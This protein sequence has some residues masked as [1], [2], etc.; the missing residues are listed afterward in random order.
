M[1][2]PKLKL[3]PILNQTYVHILA[4]PLDF[5]LRTLRGFLANQGLLLAGAIAYY[6]LLSLLPMLILVVIA[7]SHWVPQ[8]EL[9]AALGRYLEW[10]VPSQSRSLLSDVAGFLDNRA[11]IG[12][13]LVVTMLFFSSLAFSI[14]EKSMGLIFPHR[15]MVAKRHWGVSM[16]L[17][18]AFVLALSCALLAMTILSTGL[19]TMGEHSVHLLGVEWS[20]QGLSG[21][22]LYLLGLA[23][24]ALLLATLYLV[25]PVGRMPLRHALVGGVAATL[26][27]ELLRHLLVLYFTKLS[28]ASVVY[29]S[30]TTAV[31]ALLCMEILAALLLLGAQVISEY[32][33]LENELAAAEAAKPASP[34]PGGG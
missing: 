4:H 12:A 33:R 18:Y 30:L 20:L 24:E 21:L 15:G 9:L 2:L 34:A 16:L 3:P 22:M 28:K 10:L 25:L 11:Y 17:P 8:Q 23:V 6:A 32:E 27:W 7:L 29:G 26:A 1:P 5:T 31:V 19:Q 14:L 13:V